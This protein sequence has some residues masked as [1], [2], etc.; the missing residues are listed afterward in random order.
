[1]N[2]DGITYELEVR[3][4]GRG[5]WVKVDP[6]DPRFRYKPALYQEA[7]H[8]A[9]VAVASGHKVRI[10][11]VTREVLDIPFYALGTWP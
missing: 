9:K 7:H 3:W 11:R 2:P 5:R 6:K 10:T 1:M 4:G 8:S